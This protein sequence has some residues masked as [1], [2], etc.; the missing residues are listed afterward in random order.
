MF[1]D[2]EIWDNPNAEAYLTLYFER[3]PEHCGECPL[4]QANFEY[5]EDIYFD[6]KTHFCPFS[7]IDRFGC[8]VEHPKNCPI[9]YIKEKE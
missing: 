6:Y 2:K 7:E 5:E 3:M 8:K 4:Y 9:K 1:L